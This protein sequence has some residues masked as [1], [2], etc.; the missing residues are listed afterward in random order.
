MIIQLEIWKVYEINRIFAIFYD[1][2][3]LLQDFT[4]PEFQVRPGSSA[5][6]DRFSIGCLFFFG[7]TSG[8]HHIFGSTV[9]YRIANI[10]QNNPSFNILINK[11]SHSQRKKA[12]QQSDKWLSITSQDLMKALIE[13]HPHERPSCTLALCHP[14]LWTMEKIF[15][16]FCAIIAKL[17]VISRSKIKKTNLETDYDDLPI[18]INKNWKKTIEKDMIDELNS[19][20]NLSGDFVR[21]L[22]LFMGKHVSG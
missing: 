8:K 11:R 6:G 1:F 14:C 13:K 22:L 2:V 10:K 3:N 19:E 17:S 7:Y 16:F 21:D 18:V 15:N 9:E 12:S 5:A 4:A 20:R